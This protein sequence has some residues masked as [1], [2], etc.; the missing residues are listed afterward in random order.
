MKRSRRAPFV[1][2][3]AIAATSGACGGSTDSEPSGSGGVSTGGV[4]SNPPGFGG[5]GGTS[6][7]GSTSSGGTGAS[8]PSVPCPLE[9]PLEGSECPAGTWFGTSCYFPDPC[10]GRSPLVAECV[11]QTAT[12]HLLGGTECECPLT[13]PANGSSCSTSASVQCAYPTEYCCS[14]VATCYAGSWSLAVC[15][16]PPVPCPLVPPNAGDKCECGA[17][18]ECTWG[19]CGDAGTK[20]EGKCF[21][22]VWQLT[23][24]TCD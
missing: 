24:T 3:V 15:N 18:N 23:E 4:G 16:P 9:R 8:P 5:F 22:G 14:N 13:E 7:G 12:W 2:T 19:E 6:A 20:I 17:Y 21:G 1:I 11:S 10:G